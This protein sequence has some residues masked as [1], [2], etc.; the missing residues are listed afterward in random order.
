MNIKLKPCPYCGVEAIVKY[1][2]DSKL[3]ACDEC[4]P[5][6][7][8]WYEAID[9]A[10]EEWNTRTEPKLNFKCRTTDKIGSTYIEP[11]YIRK[12]DDNSIT[13][14]FDAWPNNPSTEAPKTCR[15]C[16]W[17]WED[18]TWAIPVNPFCGN[19]CQVVGYCGPDFGCIHH[20]KKEGVRDEI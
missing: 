16:R 17:W 18:N 2:I 5:S 7:A 20:E 13:Y 11:I 14:T 4:D 8:M 12:E 3:I 9:K 6:S 19:E 15:D 10:V 1:L